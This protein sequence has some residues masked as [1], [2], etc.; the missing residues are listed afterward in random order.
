M[1][2]VLLIEPDEV[3]AAAYMRALEHVGHIVEYAAS[4]QEAV[5]AADEQMPD[6]VVLELQ[7]MTHGGIEFLHEFRSYD[8]WKHIPIVIN[9]LVPPATLAKSRSVLEQ[10]YGVTACLYKPQTSLQ[11]FI[12]A[13]NDAVAA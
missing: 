5:D 8:E 11:Q 7:L 9:T 12:R 2:N 4:G 6:V 10:E 1:A 13:V 3:L